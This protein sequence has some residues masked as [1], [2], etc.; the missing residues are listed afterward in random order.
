MSRKPVSAIVGVGSTPYYPRGNSVELIGKAIIAA[1][2]DGSISV[3]N[4]DVFA[5]HSRAGAGYYDAVDVRLLME[6]EDRLA[7]GA[8]VASLA[9]WQGVAGRPPCRG[10]PMTT[11]LR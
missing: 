1:A 2:E 10:R 4:I 6:S 7:H 8:G 3:K 9:G 5:T 11:R